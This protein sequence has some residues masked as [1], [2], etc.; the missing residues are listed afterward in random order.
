MKNLRNVV[1]A[2]ILAAVLIQINTNF[3]NVSNLF[4]GDLFGCETVTDRCKPNKK[5]RFRVKT[6]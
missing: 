3:S 2:T 4:L 5:G 6:A 1:L